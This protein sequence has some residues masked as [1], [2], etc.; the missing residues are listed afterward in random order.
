MTLANLQA[1]RNAMYMLV[2]K[3]FK[4]RTHLAPLY[5]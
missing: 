2:S 3:S 4:L 1:K 5:S